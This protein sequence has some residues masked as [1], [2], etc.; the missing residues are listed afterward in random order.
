MATTSD[1]LAE[2]IAMIERRDECFEVIDAHT[3]VDE[4][5]VPVVPQSAVA[6]LLEVE[7][8]SKQFLSAMNR[9]VITTRKAGRKITDHFV[10]GTV[11][12]NPDE[13]YLTYYAAV[14]VIMATDPTS[15]FAAMAQD[16]F[17]SRT[18]NEIIEEE[19]RI[20]NRFEVNEENKR[21]A[22]TA[23]K[24]G[25]KNYAKFQAFGY[26]GMYG[27]RMLSEVAKMKGLSKPNDLLDYAGA[28]E[29][30]AHLFRITQTNA[31]LQRDR[32]SSENLACNTHY[33]VGKEVRDAIRKI[34]GTMPEKLEVS[35]KRIGEANR[36][37]RTRL[38]RALDGE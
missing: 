24:S 28:E 9:A 25:V 34:G 36:D 23:K 2:T 13:Q 14:L 3:V 18:S 38:K 31:K 15:D 26:K 20:K 12:Q 6:Q 10:P 11:F 21:L 29:L 27:G 8:G 19:K 1:K 7:V 30:A 16:Y 33:R 35:D 17:A 4:R 22:S 37:S 5:G 32:V